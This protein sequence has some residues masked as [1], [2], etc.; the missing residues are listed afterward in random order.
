MDNVTGGDVVPG[1][2]QRW[3][4]WA[5]Q[6]AEPMLIYCW[7]SVADA[8]PTVNQHW[9]NIP[10]LLWYHRRPIV[11][12]IST[13]NETWAF[14]QFWCTTLVQHWVNAVTTSGAV[15]VN[16]IFLF[17]FWWH[18]QINRN[19]SINIIIISYAAHFELLSHYKK[20]LKYKCWTRQ[21]CDNAAVSAVL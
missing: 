1:G 16:C 12:C 5:M 21:L 20:F 18:V 2:K 14:A 10:C 7:A 4:K 13:G 11:G 19:D 17:I 9:L 8:G 3:C 15:D 6:G